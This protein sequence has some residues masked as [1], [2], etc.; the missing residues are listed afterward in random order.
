MAN[1]ISK[2]LLITQSAMITGY[3]M[4]SDKEIQFYPIPDQNKLN[5]VSLKPFVWVLITIYSVNGIQLYSS[6]LNGSNVE[7]NMSQYPSGI[8]YTKT[9]NMDG[10]VITKKIVKWS[11]LIF[12]INL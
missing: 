3:Q 10:I 1:G 6:I 8:Y 5:I 2:K 9:R 4:V 7:I 12:S 11:F